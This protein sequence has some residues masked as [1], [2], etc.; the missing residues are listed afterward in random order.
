MI[1]RSR[2]M[3]DVI[4]AQAEIRPEITTQPQGGAVIHDEQVSTF[5]VSGGTPA[6]AGVTLSLDMRP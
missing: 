3:D 2:R 4:P 5:Y 1:P 6:C